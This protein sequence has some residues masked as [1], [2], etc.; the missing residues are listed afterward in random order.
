VG[1]V[2]KHGSSYQPFFVW[3]FV[4]SFS[5]GPGELCGV[6]AGGVSTWSPPKVKVTPASI[7]ILKVPRIPFPDPSS[8][9]FLPE[10]PNPPWALVILLSRL[11]EEWHPCL[12]LW[13]RML[14]TEIWAIRAPPQSHNPRKVEIAVLKL[15][16]A[17]IFSDY[18]NYE[19]TIRALAG[20][21]GKSGNQER[22][23]IA[24]RTEDRASSW[25][26][27]GRCYLQ[28]KANVQC[29]LL[30]SSP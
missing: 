15:G 22:F 2:N 8:P 1:P 18:S 9:I 23:K 21:F 28:N 27:R 6:S 10:I 16:R 25:F 30:Y 13:A 12:N 7:P 14:V 17:W 20:V 4:F 11:L 26:M 19:A 5:G 29:T 24:K 3:C